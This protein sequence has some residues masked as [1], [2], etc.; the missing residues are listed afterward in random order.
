MLAAEE[1]ESSHYARLRRYDGRPS[2]LIEFEL[3]E[4]VE[5][6]PIYRHQPKSLRAHIRYDSMQ[7]AVQNG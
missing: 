7:R 6:R 3:K 1:D 4:F 2:G 5:M